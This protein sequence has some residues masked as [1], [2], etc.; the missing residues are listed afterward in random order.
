MASNSDPEEARQ[1]ASSLHRCIEYLLRD[2]VEAGLITVALHLK[3][4]EMELDEFLS[5]KPQ[6]PESESAV[7]SG[8]AR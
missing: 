2:A 3:L 4:A 8:G 7:L 6:T 1:R 5:S